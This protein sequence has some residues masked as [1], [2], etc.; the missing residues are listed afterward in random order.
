MKILFLHG[1]LSNPETSKTAKAVKEYFNDYEVLIPDYKP[2]RSYKEVKQTL[3]DYYELNIGNC[4][5]V[6][7]GISLGGYWALNLPNFT[8]CFNVIALNPAFKYYGSLPE[9]K[10]Y[11]GGHI[12]LNMDDELLDSELTSRVYEKRFK[13]TKY[14]TGGHRMSNIDNVLIDIEGSIEHFEY[15]IP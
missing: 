2:D 4:Q 9:I 15:F 6:V 10:P 8:E 12:I 11:V 3:K 14:K 1:K 7:I 5:C 13:I